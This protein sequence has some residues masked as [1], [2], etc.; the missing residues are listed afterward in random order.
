MIERFGDSTSASVP[1]LQFSAPSL[2]FLEEEITLR[3]ALTRRPYVLGFGDQR[4][5]RVEATPHEIED[6]R[7]GY[8]L[9]GERMTSNVTL[10]SNVCVGTIQDLRFGG[11]LLWQVRGREGLRNFF[12]DSSQGVFRRWRG[13]PL[14]ARADCAVASG[15]LR[16]M[17]ILHCRAGA[18]S[19]RAVLAVRCPK[20]ARRRS[21]RAVRC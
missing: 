10:R 4:E 3:Y 16:G 18:H 21:C 6:L 1:A 13:F 20:G 2:G 9:G 19:R 12:R 11:K 5:A 14:A 7:F 17:W 15:R 8:T